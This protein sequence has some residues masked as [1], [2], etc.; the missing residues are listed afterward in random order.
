MVAI[1]ISSIYK[2]FVPIILFVW[3]CFN[4][5]WGGNAY[6]GIYILFTAYLILIDN[7]KPKIDTKEWTA[8]EVQVLGKYHLALR[9]SFGAKDM[10]CFLNGLRW[11]G[12][13]FAFLFL[14]NGMWIQLILTIIGFFL[15]ADISVRL[16]PF[17]FLGQ[18]V[19]SGQIQFMEELSTLQIIDNKLKE[20]QLRDKQGKG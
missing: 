20:K 18:A 5:A 8:S 4:P 16:D 14:F 3:A 10:S 11:S 15:T 9:F 7:L 1:I 6:V 17:F 12:I 13:L 2:L 19:N